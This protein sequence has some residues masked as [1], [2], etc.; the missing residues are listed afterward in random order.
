MLHYLSLLEYF[1]VCR[2]LINFIVDY[3]IPLMQKIRM[4]FPIHWKQTRENSI[5]TYHDE[6]SNI[7]STGI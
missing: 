4:M 3:E 6:L 1:W 2:F 7:P 5:L